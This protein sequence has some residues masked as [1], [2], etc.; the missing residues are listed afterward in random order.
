MMIRTIC[1]LAAASAFVFG[2]APAKPA[3]TK[4]THPKTAWGDPDLQGVWPGTEM[5]G[6]PLQRP[7]N[8]GDRTSLTDAEFQEKEAFLKKQEEIDNAP[9]ASRNPLIAAGGNRFLSCEDDKERC[10]DGVRI[11]PPNYWDER[12]KP[13]R[14]TSLIVE[15]ANGRVP[16]LVPDAAKAQQARAAAQKARSCTGTA[17]GCHDSWTDESLWDRCISRGALNS[18]L[19]GGYN[20]GNQIQQAPGFVII[21]NEMIH[22]SR[23]VPVGTRPHL[24]EKVR[25]WMGDSRGH[26]EGNTLVI[27]TTNFIAGADNVGGGQTSDALKTVERLTRADDNTLNYQ[28]TVTDPKVWSAPWTASF[29]LKQDKDYTIYEYGCHEG[30]YY[31]YNALKGARIAEARK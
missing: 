27:E 30:N 25:S 5:N 1:L 14:R 2:Q 22:E 7:A 6:V 21:R 24:S 28:V 9:L 17:A 18:I 4:W 16:A 15:P 12:G 31:M 29:P 13:N 8:L 20:R 10:R 3:A 19:P 11:G 26:W 23:V